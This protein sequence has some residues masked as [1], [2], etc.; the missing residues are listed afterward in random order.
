MGRVLGT[1]VGYASR[2]VGRHRRDFLKLRT[3]LLVI[4]VLSPLWVMPLSAPVVSDVVVVMHHDSAVS[5]AVQTIVAND[6]HVQVVDYGSLEYALTIH[7]TVR[8]V[9]WVSHGSKQGILAG[10]QV[11]SW[12]AFS[13]RIQMTPGKDIVL[14]CDSS[15][16]NKYVSSASVVGFNGVIDARLAGFLG[17]FLI[18]SQDPNVP[19]STIHGILS[20]ANDLLVGLFS[21]ALDLLP[22]GEIP[23]WWGVLK[24]LLIASIT[25]VYFA[26][27]ESHIPRV[28]ATRSHPILLGGFLAFIMT[29]VGYT[30]YWVLNSYFTSYP[31]FCNVMYLIFGAAFGVVLSL[32]LKGA[33]PG[34]SYIIL[35]IGGWIA[36]LF[37]LNASWAAPWSRAAFA[38]SAAI[39][40]VTIADVLLTAYWTFMT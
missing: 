13:N 19:S 36:S 5:T 23:A 1:R 11:L 6:P 39:F 24:A 28:L 8:R 18:L 17:S 12:Q 2:S 3:A 4:A 20:A 27:G 7:R 30:A 25:V 31:E 16:V 34:A 15:E 22:L 14:A 37:G 21:G 10:S 32:I 38:A 40:L 9:V 26:S 35:L 29:L 33:L